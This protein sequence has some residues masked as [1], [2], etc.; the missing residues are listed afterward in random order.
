MTR[1]NLPQD[2]TTITADPQ[3]P[4]PP[5]IEV[6]LGETPYKDV[7]LVW[8]TYWDESPEHAPVPALSLMIETDE[9]GPEP[10]AKATVNL[11][12]HSPDDGCIFVKDWAE[13]EGMFDSLVAAG[14]IESTGDVVEVNQWGDVARQGRVLP[15]YAD[16][17]RAAMA[18]GLAR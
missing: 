15:P 3:V 12:S 10:L 1:E 11:I 7:E 8:S 6:T 17:L 9:F 13:N 18:R 16:A 5:L 14:V 2:D 4:P